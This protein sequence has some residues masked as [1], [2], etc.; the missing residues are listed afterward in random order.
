MWLWGGS[1]AA[2][3]ARMG[4]GGGAVALLLTAC[5][6]DGPDPTPPCASGCGVCVPTACP[7][8][9]LTYAKVEPILAAKCVVCHDG[10]QQDAWPMT[11]AAALRAKRDEIHTV[12][13]HCQMPP[14][15]AP[16]PLAKAE[17]QRILDWI[18]CGMPD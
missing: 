8:Q 1:L 7:D 18:G 12:L 2:C 16:S 4:V 17:S 13:Q 9:S 15:N 6:A 14:A 3:W 10:K 11:S 5:P